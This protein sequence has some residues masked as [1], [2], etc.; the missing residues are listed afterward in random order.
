MLTPEGLRVIYNTM[1]N[2]RDSLEPN[3]S[4]S[5]EQ[6][7]GLNSHKSRKEIFGGITWTSKY[8]SKEDTKKCL[9]DVMLYLG[10]TKNRLRFLVGV[11]RPEQI[12]RWFN[13]VTRPSSYY[14]MRICQLLMW[15]S[16]GM[17]NVIEQTVTLE[18][19]RLKLPDYWRSDEEQSADNLIRF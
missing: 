9:T 7:G 15:K 18:D 19:R 14:W 4:S 17:L 1:Q 10:V 2:V 13:G 16:L 6:Q 5:W 3:A 12:W 8:A 11:K